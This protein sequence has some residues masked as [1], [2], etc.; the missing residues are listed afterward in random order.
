MDGRDVITEKGKKKRE[1]IF[2]IAVAAAAAV[3]YF[4]G[5]LAP[6]GGG[7]WA[8]IY[9]GGEEVERVSLAEDYAEIPVETPWGENLVVVSEGKADVIEADCPDKL[10]V[11]QGKINKNGQTIVCLPHK[12]V[13]EIEGGGSPEYD[14]VSR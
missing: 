7:V 5:L 10:C 13:V 11:K 8:V 9:V 3:L 4:S 14:T 12:L 2:I 6:K 1:I